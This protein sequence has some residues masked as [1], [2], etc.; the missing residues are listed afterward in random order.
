MKEEEFWFQRDNYPAKWL[1]EDSLRIIE[2]IKEK[3]RLAELEIGKP[4]VRKKKK[5]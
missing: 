4:K 3:C 5:K 2:S 1:N